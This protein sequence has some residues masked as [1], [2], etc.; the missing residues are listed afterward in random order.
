MRVGVWFILNRTP[1][2]ITIWEWPFA[3]AKKTPVE[4]APDHP[5]QHVPLPAR[6]NGTSAT[7]RRSLGANVRMTT[8]ASARPSVNPRHTVLPVPFMRIMPWN[9]FDAS[10]VAMM[11]V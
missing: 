2:L 3:S 8:M 4:G 9:D 11:T 1:T 10:P 7:C 5:V 6:Y